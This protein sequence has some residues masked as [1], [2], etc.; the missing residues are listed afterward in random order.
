V[1]YLLDWQK[2]YPDGQNSMSMLFTGLERYRERMTYWSIHAMLRNVIKRAGITKRIYLHLFRGT[3]AT[4]LSM[5]LKC[6]SWKR[7]WHW[8]KNDPDLFASNRF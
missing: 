2:I 6:P 3:K 7:P 4:L 1:A 8:F 5:N